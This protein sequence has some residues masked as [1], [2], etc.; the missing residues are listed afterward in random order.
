MDAFLERLFNI[1]GVRGWES[2]VHL[3]S[4]GHVVLELVLETSE[5]GLDSTSADSLD[6]DLV[7]DSDGLIT[8][9]NCLDCVLVD[10]NN[11]QEACLEVKLKVRLL[12]GDIEV[13]VSFLDG[14][15]IDRAIDVV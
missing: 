2:H 1:L 7:V 9:G 13:G 4:I 12:V 10:S 14:N 11:F 3:T 8:I 6:L 5:S 15:G